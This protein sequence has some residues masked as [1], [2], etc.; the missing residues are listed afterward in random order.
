MKKLG[1][2]LMRLPLT[3]PEDKKSIDMEHLGCMVDSF[4]EQ[5]FTY[6]DTAY[7]YHDAQS[8]RVVR[9]ALVERY[10]RDRFIL[11]T[12]LPTMYLKEKEDMARIFGEQ[13]EKCGVEY[14]DYY[15]VHNLNTAHYE[16]ATRLGAFDFVMQKK[17]EG[18]VKKIGFSFHDS[19]DVL[20]RI[21]TDHPEVDVV[22][23]QINYL[24]WESE[25]VQ[26]RLCYE[27]ARKHGKDIIVMEPVKGGQ[28]AKLP[29]E[30]E[31]KLRA[32]DPKATPAS[33]A[34]RFA[35]SLE[36][37][38]LVLSGMSDMQ[39]LEDNMS[40]MGDNFVPVSEK[41]R[42]ALFEIAESLNDARLIPC[43]ACNY[44]TEACPKKLPI[45]DAF[46]LYNRNI[47]GDRKTKKEYNAL[48][49]GSEI[50]GCLACGKC[51][52]ACPQKIEII[53]KLKTVKDRFD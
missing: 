19:A 43:T 39:Q 38:F 24:D 4:L 9:E 51:E 50:S 11:T 27:V 2:G 15:L 21:L 46:A 49:E 48:E 22:Q 29:E 23:L 30:A 35:A 33:F 36:G 34:I 6:F 12:K 13:L 26:S 40:F 17:K 25:K 47:K 28:L 18:K 31:A 37:V 7:M 5:G 8:E 10:P 3:N 20:D 1:F 32:L 41:E 44:C 16:T 53:K 42:E 52:K 45:A 14:F